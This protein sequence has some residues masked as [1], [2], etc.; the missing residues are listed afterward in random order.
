LKPSERRALEEEK[1]AQREAAER[2]A[3]LE[4]TSRA[5]DEQ[6]S[7]KHAEPFYSNEEQK[8]DGHH[9]ESFF[10]SHV[11]LIT[12]IIC[13]ALIL[14]VLGPWGID[15]LVQQ[16]RADI[17]GEEVEEK[18]NISADAV[19]LLS[20][21]G[22]D[23]TWDSLAAFNYTDFSTNDSVIRE[24]EITDTILVLRVG[25]K[26]LEGYP[27]YVRLIN[28]RTGEFIKDVRKEDVRD[29]IWDN[30]N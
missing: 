15:M 27:E 9:R 22:Y 1:R 2:E 6:P 17:F 21:M 13:M 7:F 25:G 14:T 3:E 8:G 23:M 12:F 10:S 30:T 24:Y 18:K 19:I 11:R 5:K 29:F 28:Y 20:D 26:T 4:K 16:R